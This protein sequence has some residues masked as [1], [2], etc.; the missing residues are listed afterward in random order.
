MM[1]KKDRAYPQQ[2]RH[3]GDMIFSYMVDGFEDSQNFIK[4]NFLLMDSTRK[5]VQGL[6][7]NA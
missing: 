6:S 4:W 7:S 3:F 1:F 2:I 5:S